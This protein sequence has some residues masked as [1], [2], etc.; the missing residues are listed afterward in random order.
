MLLTIFYGC[1]CLVLALIVV[2]ATSLY[3]ERKKLFTLAD[4]A[5]LASAEAFALADVRVAE[6]RLR[7]ALDP[8]DVRAAAVRYLRQVPTSL[9]AELVAATT[10]DG[11]SASVTL[12]SEWRPPVVAMFVP[13]GVRV[14][15]TATAR[16]V[17]D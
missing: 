15:V 10:T 16:S 9:D 7:V 12:A 3:L 13:A 17:F 2:A 14:E 8:R 5:A 11:R 4:G 1:L 6:S